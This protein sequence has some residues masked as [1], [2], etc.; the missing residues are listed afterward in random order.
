MTEPSG[1]TQPR[2]VDFLRSVAEDNEKLRAFNRDPDKVLAAANLTAE[3]RD[4]LR[5]GDLV[6]IRDAVR[7]EEDI[8]PQFFFLVVVW[9][10]MSKTEKIV[11]RLLR[12]LRL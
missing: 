9:L 1:S 12:R 8:P 6:R 3:Q 7:L 11:V 10:T 4:V 2:I 5:S